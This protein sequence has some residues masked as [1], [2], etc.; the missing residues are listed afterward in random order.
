MMPSTQ[1]RK[2]VNGIVGL[3]AVDVMHDFMGLNAP[4]MVQFPNASML[5][6]KHSIDLF[7]YV[8]VSRDSPES[9][10][11][12]YGIGIPMVAP[13]KVMLDAPIPCGGFV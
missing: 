13:S 1:N 4:P 8:P 3:V 11:T 2:I 5:K 9:L 10:S 12:D 6:N 7:A